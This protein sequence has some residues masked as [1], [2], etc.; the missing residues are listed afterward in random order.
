MLNDIRRDIDHAAGPMAQGLRPGV[1]SIQQVPLP[2]RD[3]DIAT[4]DEAI[5]LD[6]VL[7]EGGGHIYQVSWKALSNNWS[8]AD[9]SVR[10][11][12]SAPNHRPVDRRCGGGVG[13]KSTRLDKVRRVWGARCT[14]PCGSF[15]SGTSTR[16]HV[17][18]GLQC[19]VVH[20]RQAQAQ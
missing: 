19:K 9:S 3:L 13:D 4:P 20:W 15:P 17:L 11:P 7:S 12:A 8:A 1:R 2:P 6:K 10:H 18:L 5:S 16:C 14:P